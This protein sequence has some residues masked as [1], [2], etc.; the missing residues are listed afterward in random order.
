MNAIKCTTKVP[1]ICAPVLQIFKN[2]AIYWGSDRLSDSSAMSQLRFTFLR[3][4]SLIQLT[5]LLVYQELI[6]VIIKISIAAAL[7]W[8]ILALAFPSSITP[9]EQSGFFQSLCMYFNHIWVLKTR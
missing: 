6:T 2:T 7:S 9:D 5:I 1:Q 4:L 3:A 8:D